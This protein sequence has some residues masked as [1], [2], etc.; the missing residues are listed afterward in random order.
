MSYANEFKLS[1]NSIAYSP[2]TVLYDFVVS[3]VVNR[4]PE[5]SF[6]M[7]NKHRIYNAAS[8]VSNVVEVILKGSDLVFLNALT[9]TLYKTFKFDIDGIM[10]QGHNYAY[11][12]MPYTLPTVNY[13][14]VTINLICKVDLVT[15][16][17]TYEVEA[18]SNDY[19]EFKYTD[20]ASGSILTLNDT[21]AQSA[22]SNALVVQI[23]R[24]LKS[25]S[26]YINDVNNSHAGYASVIQKTAK[27]IVARLIDSTG[28]Y[29]YKLVFD[30]SSGDT[31]TMT[32]VKVLPTATYNATTQ[33]V[34][35]DSSTVV[36]D[37]TLQ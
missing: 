24:S 12:K 30:T 27:Y 20:G 33:T 17:T 16:T 19:Y 25:V 18:D 36:S 2:T 14:G 8:S 15:G 7:M 4:V 34:V 22:S 5:F 29:D 37:V 13:N 32:T 9:R 28:V 1:D 26:V 6:T 21:I 23:L 31:T 10:E 35:F 11:F 3:F